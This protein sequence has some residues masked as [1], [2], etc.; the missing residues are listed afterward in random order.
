MRTLTTLSLTVFVLVAGCNYNTTNTLACPEPTALD[1]GATPQTDAQAQTDT[2]VDS[3]S[4]SGT[5]APKC[6]V[7][8]PG[9]MFKVA[10][11]TMKYIVS[12][13]GKAMYFPFP[14][15]TPSDDDGVFHSWRDSDLGL[16]TVS[17]D[18]FDWMAVSN[19]YP[20][21]VNLRSGSFIVKRP[22]SDQLYAVLPN[23]TLAKIPTEIAA[24]LYAPAYS[25]GVNDSPVVIPDYLWPN[26]VNRGPDVIDAHVHPG[27]IFIISGD[28][29]IYYAPD[30]TVREVTDTGFTAN[31][32]QRRFVRQVALSATQGMS[33][34]EPIDGL[35]PSIADPT[36]GG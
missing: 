19:H 33:F 31:H 28:T 9:D 17:Q 6:P 30:G 32:F 5:D 11:F 13:E 8:V 7:L 36:Q 18:C 1:G 16:T 23:N 29:A 20:A 10:N 27:M 4:D 24:A 2:K 26:F 22:L 21:G 3:G 35:V 15:S 25:D 14:F 34:G 12:Q